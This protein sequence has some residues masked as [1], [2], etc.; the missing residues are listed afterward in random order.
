V[1]DPSRAA[2]APSVAGAWYDA[3]SAPTSRRPRRTWSARHLTELPDTMQ[4]L[5]KATPA[6][7]LELQQLPVPQPGPGDVLIRVTAASICGTD[8]HI[9]DWDEWSAHRI[10]PPIVLGHEFAGKVAGLGDGVDDVG[11][12]TPVSAEGHVIDPR[13]PG[14]V[15]GQ[16]HLAPGLEVLGIDRPGGFAEYVV[17]PRRNLWVNPPDLPDEIASLQDPFGNAVHTV[18]AQDVAGKRLLI[19]GAGLIGLMSIPVAH[20]VGARLVVAADINPRRLAMAREAGAHAVIDAR[21][22]D[23][24]ARVRELTDGQGVDVVLEMSGSP[25]AIDDALDAVRPGGEVAALGL[26]SSTVPVDWGNK[27]V[28]KGLTLRGIYGRRIWG[29][30]HRMRGLL[31]TGAVDLRPFITHEFPLADFEEAFGVMKDGSAGKVILR[32]SPRA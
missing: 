8:V 2:G 27:I 31:E 14:V 10:K 29:T 6:P 20:A 18:F 21:T 1:A 26:P 7:G 4:A 32:P 17:V 16:E 13:G 9:Y 24:P 22:E 11:L 12:G 15:P 3:F 30:W 28:L 23:V 19:S 5:V 25:T